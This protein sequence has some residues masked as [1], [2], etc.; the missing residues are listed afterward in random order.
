MLNG[1]MFESN[2]YIGPI[3]TT[4]K[5]PARLNGA[6]YPA[7]AK[8]ANFSTIAVMLTIVITPS[9]DSDA[10]KGKSRLTIKNRRRQY[11]DERLP[12]R[13]LRYTLKN[14]HRRKVG[15]GQ[16]DG[17]CVLNDFVEIAEQSDARDDTEHNDG[18]EKKQDGKRNQP[19]GMPRPACTD[20]RKQSD[21]MEKHSRKPIRKTETGRA[22]IPLRGNR[23]CWFG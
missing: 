2:R 4:S 16:E 13:H 6:G 19:I 17:A 18:E 7:I 21:R 3:L 12:K 20:T 23:F 22:G 11:R 5:A 8:K 9:I 15:I 14:V 10:L 1:L